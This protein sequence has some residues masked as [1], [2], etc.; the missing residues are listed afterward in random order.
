VPEPR[1]KCLLLIM[2]VNQVI[3]EMDRIERN[4]STGHGSINHWSDRHQ[5]VGDP[6]KGERE[7]RKRDRHIG[8]AGGG[9]GGCNLKAGEREGDGWG[10]R[11]E[12]VNLLARRKNK[13]WSGFRNWLTALR[14]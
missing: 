11:G 14:S 4:V 9:G 13:G 10:R 6:G 8:G 3:D 12:S 5:L 1:I 2:N 7:E